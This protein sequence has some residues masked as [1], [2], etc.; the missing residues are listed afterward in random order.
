VIQSVL[1]NAFCY[2]NRSEKC[3][4]MI[5]ANRTKSLTY[6]MTVKCDP[7]CGTS[8]DAQVLGSVLCKV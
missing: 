4:V 3:S 1:N 8:R 7:I 2:V 5:D 6:C